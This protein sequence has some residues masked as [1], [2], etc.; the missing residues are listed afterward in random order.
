[1]YTKVKP[2]MF[3]MKRWLNRFTPFRMLIIRVHL[4]VLVE[5]TKAKKRE[6]VYHPFFSCRTRIVAVE[7]VI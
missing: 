3:E 1:M 4:V 2:Q 7:F 6:N 5:V